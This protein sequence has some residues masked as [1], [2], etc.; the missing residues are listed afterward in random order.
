M[1]NS[2][3]AVALGSMF[4]ISATSSFTTA[5]A[6]ENV[7]LCKSSGSDQFG[8]T[9]DFSVRF[10]LNASG[11]VNGKSATVDFS[12]RKSGETATQLVLTK[13]PLTIRSAFQDI[14]Y[15]AEFLEGLE[16]GFAL[17]D[18]TTN[19]NYNYTVFTKDPN[20]DLRNIVNKVSFETGK[21]PCVKTEE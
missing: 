21:V 9:L 20:N 7:L 14:I 10:P 1:K 17:R 18:F 13:Y 11:N 8:N 3:I 19:I 12:V 15:T 16:V 5:L 4:A 6:N 2:A